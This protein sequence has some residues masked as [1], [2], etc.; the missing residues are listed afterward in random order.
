MC[1]FDLVGRECATVA[2][3]RFLCVR[4][5][6]QWPRFTKVDDIG[7]GDVKSRREQVLNMFQVSP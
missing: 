6:G 3:R 7:I 2:Y 4:V 5:E 1:G